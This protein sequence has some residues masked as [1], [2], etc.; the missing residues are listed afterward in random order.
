M[1]SA[2]WDSAKWD[3]A[4]RAY[5][6]I[7][8]GTLTIGLMGVGSLVRKNKIKS[9]SSNKISEIQHNKYL[10]LY[11]RIFSLAECCTKQKPRSEVDTSAT[12]HLLIPPPGFENLR[13]TDL[14]L[15]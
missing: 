2:K 8:Q 7:G 6:I 1:L 9:L 14:P 3:S 4:K 13:E 10:A 12:A 11:S 5:T 15:R